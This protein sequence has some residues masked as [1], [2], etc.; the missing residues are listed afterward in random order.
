[1]D[2]ERSRFS[3]SLLLLYSDI[4]RILHLAGTE[5]DVKFNMNVTDLER[6]IVTPKAM[7]KK[8]YHDICSH[9]ESSAITFVESEVK[10]PS[11]GVPHK[12]IMV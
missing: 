9:I 4:K 7:T 10:M 1:M 6:L 12:N 8:T 11:M 3:N 5:I 2:F